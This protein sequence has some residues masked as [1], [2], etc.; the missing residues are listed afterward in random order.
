MKRTDNV[1]DLVM[2]ALIM[3]IVTVCTMFI[4]VP[5]PSGYVHIGT[6]IVFLSIAVLGWKKGAFVSAVGTALADLLAG[7]ASWAPGSFIIV[8]AMA[9]VYGYFIDKTVKKHGGIRNGVDADEIIGAVLAIIVF[10]VG[11]YVYGATF[12]YGW[13]GALTV[14]IPNLMQ[15]LVGVVFARIFG[16]A[17]CKATGGKYFQYRF[18]K[19]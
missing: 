8:L 3:A 14:V 7:Y 19:K 18:I 12:F 13:A 17:I 11:Y 16:M 1:T 15:V 9:G 6:V 10:L 5:T 4:K 2:A